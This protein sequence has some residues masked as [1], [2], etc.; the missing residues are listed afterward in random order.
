MVSRYYELVNMIETQAKS[1]GDVTLKMIS[2]ERDYVSDQI[3][4][5]TEMLSQELRQL[6]DQKT[7]IVIALIEVFQQL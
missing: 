6:F 3:H 5:T 4:S 7:R 2:E 1:T